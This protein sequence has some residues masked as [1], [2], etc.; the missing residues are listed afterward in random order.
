MKF[1]HPLAV[2]YQKPVFPPPFIYP[3]VWLQFYSALDSFKF[4]T[5]FLSL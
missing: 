2:A 3:D 4:S 1:K 5:A